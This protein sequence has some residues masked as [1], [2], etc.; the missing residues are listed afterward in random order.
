MIARFTCEKCAAEL[1]FRPGTTSLACD[2]CGHVQIFRRE[3]GR[4][5]SP[6]LGAYHPEIANPVD[7]LPTDVSCTEAILSVPQILFANLAAAS[8]MLNALWLHLCDRLHYS[9]LAFDI[10]DGKMQPLPIPAPTA[11]KARSCR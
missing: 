2:Y 6:H 4:D 5:L 11:K 7:R 3:R 10:A 1:E 8:S 9:E